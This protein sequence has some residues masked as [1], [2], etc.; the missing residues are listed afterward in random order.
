MLVVYKGYE[1]E[2]LE[3][4]KDKRLVDTEIENKINI[5]KTLDKVSKEVM[6]AITQNYTRL[7][8]EDLW[9]TYEELSA[10]H[11]ALTA[12]AKVFNIKI[13]VYDN[14]KYYNIYPVE[15]YDKEYMESLLKNQNDDSYENE[16]MDLIY[17]YVY[18]INGKYYVQYNNYEYDDRDQISV[19]KRYQA[20]KNDLILAKDVEFV[21]ELS[22][23]KELYLQ[24]VIEC[25]K[26]KK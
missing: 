17:S 16:N 14:N 26:Y 24:N 2:F 12:I 25:E 21:F 6:A 1:K 18:E 19:K 9:I 20:E 15:Y 10:C 13:C 3:R 7:V 5:S 23:N 11:E 4:E 8:N 22:D